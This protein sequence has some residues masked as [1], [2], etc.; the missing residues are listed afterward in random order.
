M[1][2]NK[3]ILEIYRQSVDVARSSKD[4]STKSGCVLASRLGEVISTGFNSMPECFDLDENWN[5]R[6]KKYSMVL[7]AEEVAIFNLPNPRRNVDYAAT[8][9]PPCSSCARLLV[10]LGVKY[11]ISDYSNGPTERWHEEIQKANRIF[12]AAGVKVINVSDFEEYI[13]LEEYR[14]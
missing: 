7:H 9:W 11:M 12:D 10:F 6:S 14:E 2:N 3:K 8:N 1:I 4:P 13:K 5:D